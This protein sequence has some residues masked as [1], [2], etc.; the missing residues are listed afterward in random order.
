MNTY[1]LW[2]CLCEHKS[3][4]HIDGKSEKYSQIYTE[5]QDAAI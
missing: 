2:V 1:N 4:L 3:E 5:Q